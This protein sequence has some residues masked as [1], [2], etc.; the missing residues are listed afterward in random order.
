VKAIAWIGV[1][2]SVLQTILLALRMGKP[3]WPDFR[4]PAMTVVWPRL[5]PLIFG[6]TYYKSDAMIERYLLSS[7]E[8]GSLS[9]YFLAQQMYGAV[10]QV[11]NKAIAVPY[12]SKL[13]KSYS[14]NNINDSEKFYSTTLLRVVVISIFL[15]FTMV[16]FGR[17]TL[18]ILIG[19]GKFDSDKVRDL[20]WMLIWLSGVFVG[21]VAG[22]VISLSFYAQN[23]TKTPA[24]ISAM[25]Y[26][27]YLPIKIFSYLKFGVKGL[28]IASSLY[29]I[30][31]CGI[32]LYLLRRKRS[33]GIR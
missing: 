28:A 25:T 8:S 13:S 11:F 30:F 22:Q 20:W 6:A 17:Q 21:G 4:R 2:K 10:N 7:A 5:K 3:V 18:T 12:F 16:A 15:V 32:L 19:Y 31:D 1:A 29:Y 33:C 27:A 24:K 23:D 14:N 26:T 9:L